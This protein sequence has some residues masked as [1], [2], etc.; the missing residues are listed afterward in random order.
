MSLKE[1][2][3]EGSID[4]IEVNCCCTAASMWTIA[5]ALEW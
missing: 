1:V 2:G 3:I 4:A 5:Q